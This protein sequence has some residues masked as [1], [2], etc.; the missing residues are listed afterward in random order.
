[1][2]KIIT[3]VINQKILQIK[4]NSI[5][6]YLKK[7]KKKSITNLSSY[8]RERSNGSAPCESGRNAL[9]NRARGSGF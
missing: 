2:V 5:I 1:M 3:C 8:S 4:K 9:T 7:M 6:S